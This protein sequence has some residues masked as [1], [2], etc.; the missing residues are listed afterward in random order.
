M[1]EYKGLS[2]PTFELVIDVIKRYTELEK[3]NQWL[4]EDLERKE[5]ELREQQLEYQAWQEQKDYLFEKMYRYK[6]LSNKTKFLY[7]VWL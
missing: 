1:G 3:E 6:D 4:R 2:T 7:M 5:E